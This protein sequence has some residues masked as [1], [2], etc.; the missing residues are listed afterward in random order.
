M[1]EVNEYGVDEQYEAAVADLKPINVGSSMTLRKEI[2]CAICVWGS[3]CILRNP[4]LNSRPT[5]SVC[6]LNLQ[7]T[8]VMLAILEKNNYVQI[9]LE[10]EIPK[11]PYH[12]LAAGH[13]DGYKAAI[14]EMLK[15]GW[16]KRR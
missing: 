16:V 2:T 3:I 9:N 14:E 1:S 11:N 8:D 6:A 15:Q 5:D 7:R 13:F 12:H 10:A 4:L